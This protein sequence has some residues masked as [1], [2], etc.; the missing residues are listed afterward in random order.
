MTKILCIKD[1]A[2]FVSISGKITRF[3]CCF[4][5][6]CL[7]DSS[8]VYLLGGKYVSSYCGHIL[9]SSWCM[10]VLG[11]RR[12]ICVYLLIACQSAVSDGALRDNRRGMH[13]VCC[14]W[15]IISCGLFLRG[16]I[17]SPHSLPN[18]WVNF[19]F[20][21]FFLSPLKPGAPLQSIG[22]VS[23]HGFP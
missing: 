6:P 11:L 2:C 15:H 13:P 14:A 5:P 4:L 16:A 19:L 1:N 21:F 17:L 9:T 10:T 3:W 23:T 8:D 7:S 22:S 20:F 18:V 12:R